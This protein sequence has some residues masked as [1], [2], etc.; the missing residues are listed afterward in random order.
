[1]RHPVP[2]PPPAPGGGLPALPVTTGSITDTGFT[3]AAFSN[4][5]H[6]R[7][8][9]QCL[10][11]NRCNLAAPLSLQR[12]GDVVTGPTCACTV[13][14]VPVLQGEGAFC[15]DLPGKRVDSPVGREL[16]VSHSYLPHLRDPFCAS[17]F[18]SLG[19]L[20]NP[21]WFWSSIF[22]ILINCC[23]APGGQPVTAIDQGSNP[24]RPV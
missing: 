23:G 5:L 19:E 21:R 18:S 6:C 1:M 14:P 16:G 10:S 12:S 7:L 22:N 9:P 17:V 8:Q 2:P 20:V 13:Q 3:D 24:G 4:C 15:V 11:L